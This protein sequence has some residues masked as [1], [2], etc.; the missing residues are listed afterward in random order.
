MRQ[1][2]VFIILLFLA[3]ISLAQINNGIIT[4]KK[5]RTGFL[6]EKKGFELNKEEQPKYYKTVLMIDQE[7]KKLLEDIQFLLEYNN[8]ESTFKVKK[9]LEIES[10][11][12]FR[13][14]IGPD[15][16]K[17]YYTN[18][19]EKENLYQVDA[20][21][22]LFIVSYPKIEWELSNETKKIG[23]YTCYKATTIKISKSRR[24]IIKTPITVWYSPDLAF[25]FGPI[26]YGGLPGLIMELSMRNYKYYVSTIELN[27]KKEA[28]IKKPTKGKQVTETEFK[29]IGIETMSNYKKG[30]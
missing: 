20:F 2:R 30:F 19:V 7:T 6:S 16:S 8:V 21:G 12:F 14:A 29:E 15:G 10:N 18:I 24:G 3:N 13:A 1:S 28:A 9:I 4:Y 25:P 27:T 17:I 23:K 11:R 5:E 22:E 26:G